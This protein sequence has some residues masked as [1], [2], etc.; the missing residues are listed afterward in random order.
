MDVST[1][2]AGVTT[3]NNDS[4]VAYDTIHDERCA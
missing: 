3:T 2:P 1:D 4:A